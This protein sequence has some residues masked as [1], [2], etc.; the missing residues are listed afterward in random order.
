MYNFYINISK[1][2]VDCMGSVTVII[3]KQKSI[4]ATKYMLAFFSEKKM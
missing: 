2:C 4:F 3:I 1:V